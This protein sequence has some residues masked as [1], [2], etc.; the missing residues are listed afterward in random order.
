MINEIAIRLYRRLFGAPGGALPDSGADRVLDGNTAT[1]LTELAI[2]GSAALGG[3]F[4]APGAEQALRQG[5]PEAASPPWLHLAEGPRGALAAAMGQAAAGRRATVFLS[6]PD[7]AAAQDLL[8]GA[9]GRHLPLVIHLDNRA[10]PLQGAAPGSGHAALQQVADSGCFVLFAANVQEAVDLTLVARRVSEAALIPGVVAL[11]GEQTALSAQEVAL[12][13]PELVTAYLGSAGE[14]M[15][16]PTPAQTLLFGPERPR[17]PRWHDPDLPLLQGPLQQPEAYALGT[18]GN[19]PYFTDHLE[20][21]L[22]QAMEAFGRQTG[23]RYQGLS[24]YRME[25][26]EVALLLQGGTVELARSVADHLRRNAKLKIGVLGLRVLHPFPGA[27]LARHLDGLKRVAVLE[28]QESPGAGEPP[29]LRELRCALGR[30]QENQRFGS[31]THPGYPALEGRRLPRLCSARYGLGGVAPRGTDLAAYAQRLGE[32]DLPPLFLGVDFDHTSSVHPKRQVLLDQIRRAYPGIGDLGLRERDRETDLRPEGALSLGVRR[33]PTHGGAALTM[34][35]GQLLQRLLGGRIR[36][37]PGSGT[38]DCAT[39][40]TDR[41]LQ[42]PAGYGLPGGDQ[43]LDLLFVA[44]REQLA[45]ADLPRGVRPGGALLIEGF[46]EDAA[47]WEAMGARARE[48][49]RRLGPRL[50]RLPAQAQPLLPAV[51]GGAAQSELGDARRL[52]ALFSVLL[53]EG[54]LEQTPRR[55]LGAWG[56]GLQRLDEGEREALQ[57]A[58]EA[59]LEAPRRVRQA[60]P[61]GAVPGE[62]AWNDRVPAAVRQLGRLEQGPGS[63]PR[64]WDQVGVLYRNGERADLTADPFLTLGSVPPLSATFRDMSGLRARFPRFHPQRCSGCGRCWGSCPDSAIGVAALTPAALLDRAIRE[65]GAD[66]VRQV[67]SKL[68]ARISAM[69]RSGA[70]EGGT[71]AEWLQQ[72]WSWLQE[73]APLPADR[74]AVIGDG[75]GALEA[76]FGPLPLAPT[77][78]LFGAGERAKKD[79]GELLVLA[80]NPDACKGCGICSA[81]CPEEALTAE[82][83]TPP[84]LTRARQVWDAWQAL[85]D[86]ASATIERV[87]AEQGMDPM[88]A[89][90][91]SRYCALALAGG[92]GAEPGSGERSALRLALAAAEYQ[93]QPLL[94]RFIGELEQRR[95]QVNGEIRET[96]QQA[97]PGDDLERLAERLQSVESRQVEIAALARGAAVDSARLE[98]LVELAR[99][100]DDTCFRLAEGSQGLGRA[101]YGLV[102][103]PGS[104]ARW[105]GAFPDNPFQAPVTLDHTGAAPQLAAGVAQGQLAPA[106][107]AIALLRRARLVLGEMKAD[108]PGAETDPDWASLTAEERALCPPLFLVGSEAELGGRGFAQVAWLLAGDLPVKILV[109]SELDLGL[110]TRGLNG[111]DPLA[112]LADP[113][114]DLGL[115]ALAQR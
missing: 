87:T 86:T 75:I 59:G 76:R 53:A 10:L 52:G 109:L 85:P 39:W 94:H 90:L 5:V 18:A 6:G 36:G 102:L 24:R 47:L 22:Q 27:E 64:F 107:D 3:T 104:V 114:T 55:V 78:P 30:A 96:L 45:A 43:P 20:E 79:G 50:Y 4:P 111:G 42:A 103:A 32:E 29:L 14:R 67:A 19:R 33:L 35:L 17:V 23:R 83:Q 99:A 73:K 56:E 92:D 108:G 61:E 115:M 2:C 13:G 26:A 106:L 38:G 81:V 91:M 15:A 46:T 1:A 62:P 98:R 44:G 84:L 95:D 110:D 31:E 97:L 65:T 80:V 25:G 21:L 34:E 66:A 57:Q 101:R 71:L 54:M 60:A 40:V 100:L 9:V 72:A 48:A 69:G 82:P 68:A 74:T 41:L 12:P 51:G 11:D 37:L 93:L 112:T 16:S 8:A 89:L 7:L 77:E 28:R 58:F 113:V 49:L 70:A 88:S 63:L 105:A